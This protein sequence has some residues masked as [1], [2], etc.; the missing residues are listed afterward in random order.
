MVS[1]RITS[2]VSTLLFVNAVAFTILMHNC[3]NQEIS[4][5][6]AAEFILST[7]IPDLIADRRGKH[8]S[9]DAAHSNTHF[10]GIAQTR[11][12]CNG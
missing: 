11:I 7:F 3:R 4:P 5:T 12:S 10:F 1:V 9:T 8:I 2:H 6:N